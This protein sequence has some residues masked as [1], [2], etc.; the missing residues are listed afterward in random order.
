[1]TPAALAR[2]IRSRRLLI[3]DVDGTLADTAP[4]HAR[5][6]KEVLNPFGFTFD[7]ADIAGMTTEA[8][9]V[10]VFGASRASLDA[11]TLRDLADRKRIIARQILENDLEPFPGLIAFMDE[12]AGTQAA[13][14]SSGSRSTVMLSLRK[15]GI[16]QRFDPIICG[17]DVV[18]GKPDPE[19]FLSVLSLTEIL[20]GDALVFEDSTS[21]LQA[22]RRAGIDAIRIDPALIDAEEDGDA[23]V[24]CAWP[25]LVSALRGAFE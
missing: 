8:A 13:I 5:A 15:M 17:E 11:G 21:G 19:P 23:T 22:A 4:A 2:L 10:R 9:L 1:M 6:F 3:F 25:T 12:T 14:C 20:A 18:R 7:Y 24:S 16:D